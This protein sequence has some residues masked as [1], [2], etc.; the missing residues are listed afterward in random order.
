M[1]AARRKVKQNK[2][3]SAAEKLATRPTVSKKRKS[4]EFFKGICHAPPP[5]SRRSF[6][7]Y[8]GRGGGGVAIPVLG[9]F[10]T[11]GHKVQLGETAYR[12]KLFLVTFRLEVT[13]HRICTNGPGT[14]PSFLFPYVALVLTYIQQE[15]QRR[16]RPTSRNSQWVLASVKCSARMFLMER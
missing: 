7:G 1:H 2:G 11:K 5:S 8:G 6:R 12:S 3:G 10:C 15:T 14:P 13:T 16:S 4:S 9:H